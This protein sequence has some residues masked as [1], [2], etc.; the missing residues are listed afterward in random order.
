[1]ATIYRRKEPFKILMFYLIDFLY[2][3][4]HQIRPRILQQDYNRALNV[5]FQIE[6]NVR[7]I[8]KYKE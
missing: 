3:I 7:S 5:L 8:C 4:A 6:C 1:Y 2:I